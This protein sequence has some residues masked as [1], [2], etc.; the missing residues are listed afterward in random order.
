MGHNEAHH[1]VAHLELTVLL[2][3]LQHS[4]HDFLVD[5]R[6]A[7]GVHV[8]EGKLLYLNPSRSSNR[9]RL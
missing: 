4:Q 3:L 7:G 6:A 8:I 2:Q 1:N 9:S 5:L